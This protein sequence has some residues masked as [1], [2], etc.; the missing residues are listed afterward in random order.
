MTK[1]KKIRNWHAVDA[2]FRNSAGAFK[3]MVRIE[4]KES[5]RRFDK[6][7]FRTTF[8]EEIEYE[9]LVLFEGFVKASGSFF[10]EEE[11]AEYNEKTKQEDELREY[12]EQFSQRFYD[13]EEL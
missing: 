8:R 1:R 9:D 3:N 4:N 10:A 12:Y 13:E 7:V 11:E 2:Q 5:C 6:R